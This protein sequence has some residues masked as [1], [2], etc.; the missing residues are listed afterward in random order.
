MA[1]QTINEQ[2]ENKLKGPDPDKKTDPDKKIED[3][4]LILIFYA[5]LYLF[6]MAN[7]AI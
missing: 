7:M 5:S 2:G 4:L 1:I 6:K 3:K